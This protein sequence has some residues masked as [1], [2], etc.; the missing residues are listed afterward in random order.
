MNKKTRDWLSGIFVGLFVIIT[1]ILSLIATGY[2][3]NLSWP[4]NFSRALQKTGTIALDSDPK[5]AKV[6]ITGEQERGFTLNDLFK[7]NK[8]LTTPVKIKNLLPGEYLVSF[9]LDGYWPYEKKL[10]VNATQTTFLENIILFKKSLPLK[11]VDATK[12]EIEYSPNNDYVW[13]KNNKK[14]ISL[15]TEEVVYEHIAPQINWTNNDKQIFD[16][17]QYVNLENGS[18]TDYQVAIGIPVEAQIQGNKITYLEKNNLTIYNTSDKS[19]KA[20]AVQGEV[21]LYTTNETEV[22]AITKENKKVK[23]NSYSTN[24]G[25]LTASLELLFE[26]KKYLVKQDKN[27]HLTILDTDHET[28]Y[29]INLKN[30]LELITIIRGVTAYQ[31][32]NNDQLFYVTGSEIYLYDLK[33]DKSW[34]INRLGEKISS[35]AW[36]NS[37]NYLVFASLKN[38]GI[39]DL[40]DNRNDITGIWGADNI[41]A[42][43]L[44]DKNQTLYFHSLVGNDSALYKINLR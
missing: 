11:V 26:A 42:L 13:L 10:R 5:G 41:S 36:S 34:L 12:Q 30:K 3:F 24:S 35:L 20:I 29:L 37:N 6:I 9:N 4:L 23:L 22:L 38:I 39:I 15:K 17:A 43:Q 27:G 28:L 32:K 21:L 33:Q 7:K 1:I 25:E 8:E 40:S 31:W 2:R 19:S 18:I 16:A 44:D 14:I